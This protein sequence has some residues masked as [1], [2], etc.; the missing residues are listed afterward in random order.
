[1]L[2]DDLVARLEAKTGAK[3][4]DVVPRGGGG[5]SRQGAEVTLTWPDGRTQRCYLAY[6]SRAGD[7]R[8][9][10]FFTREVAVLAALSGPWA[11]RRVK[12]PR[13]VA[14][15][16]EALALLTELVPG[17]DAYDKIEDV[18]ERDAIV[19]DFIAQ[20]ADLHAID[21]A[22]HPLDGFGDPGIPV[23][24]RMHANIAQWR[25]DN[26]N[27]A[28]D[29]VLQLAYNWL[30]DNLPEDDG[31]ATLVHGDTGV[32]N[33]MMD[34]GK[35]TALLDWELTH[36]GDPMEDLA[37]IWVRML[38]QPFAPPAE[39]FRLYEEASGRPVDVER[40]KY[41][42]LYFQLSFTTNSQ[43]LLSDPDAPE[44]AA[45]GTTLLF[46]TTHMRV[47]VE[48]MAELSGTA[49]TEPAIP[50]VPPGEAER[51]YDI[52]LRDL[53][54]IIVPRIEDQQASA[55]AKALARTV[56]W[57][58]GRDRYGAAFREAELAE[59]EA[60]LGERSVSLV[61][62]R[63]ALARRIADRSIA[64]EDALALCHSRVMRD[65][66]TMGD[67]L[68]RYRTTYFPPLD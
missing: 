5:A 51:T 2:A 20:L 28:P 47:I 49:L 8:R 53:K 46:A 29:P 63:A 26:L 15:D 17:H 52:V 14:H 40:V 67:A 24:E 10:P 35:V 19:R 48:Q 39:I 12:A 43:A 37:Q 42:R 60:A 1:M 34:D 54:D 6:D 58:K 65:T 4:G 23:R 59:L 50:D 61:E 41:L 22:A 11:N 13:L 45:L 68:G 16:T 3:I 33:F 25:A 64:F 56:K 66:E 21:I 44:P 36:Y 30:D 32:G 55:K 57:W 9:L 38:F 27:R 31:P 18:D 62:G 7:P